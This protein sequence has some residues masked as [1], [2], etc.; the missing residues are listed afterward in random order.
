MAVG[1][2]FVWKGDKVLASL[3]EAAMEAYWLLGQTALT[4]ATRDVPVD[5]GTMLRSGTVTVGGLPDPEATYAAAESG[6]REPFSKQRL[7][8]DKGVCV[9][10]STPYA[11]ALHESPHWKGRLK[12]WTK[13][14]WLERAIPK[15][16]KKWPQIV[17][18]AFDK[19]KSV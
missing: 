13:W 14:K 2:R 11:I 4:E 19:L 10:Y 5:T 3:E 16:R 7:G 8:E 9:S 17:K 6:Q 18:R 12:P 1:D 15:A